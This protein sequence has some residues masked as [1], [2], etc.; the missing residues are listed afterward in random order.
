M[1]T[2]TILHMN[3]NEQSEREDRS[4]LKDVKRQ[5]DRLTGE[6]GKLVDAI[7]G[8]DLGNEGLLPRVMNVES[9]QQDLKKRLDDIELEGKRRGMYIMAVVSLISIILGTLFKT[10][11]DKFSK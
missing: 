10:F 3:Q 7:Q 6:V 1:E 9:A 4:T 5:M 11:I 2:A 8:N